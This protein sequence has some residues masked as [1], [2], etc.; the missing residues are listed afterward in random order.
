MLPAVA[1]QKKQLQPHDFMQIFTM[2]GQ[3]MAGGRIFLLL[4]LIAFRS[5]VMMVSSYCFQ[6]TNT[7]TQGRASASR[8]KTKS[9]AYR[10]R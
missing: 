4:H 1:V 5:H 3:R 2:F 6:R 9:Q 7:R 8:V 10:K